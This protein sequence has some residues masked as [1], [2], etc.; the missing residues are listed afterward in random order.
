MDNHQVCRNLA[1]LSLG[2]RHLHGTHGGN[3]LLRLLAR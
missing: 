2:V 3:H 1:E